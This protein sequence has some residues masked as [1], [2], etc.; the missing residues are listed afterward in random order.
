MDQELLTLPENLSSPPILVILFMAFYL[1]VTNDLYIVWLSNPVTLT[2]PDEGYSRNVSY[3]L[4]NTY[5][6]IIC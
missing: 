5:I 6:L 4:N 2:V 1:L 3:A